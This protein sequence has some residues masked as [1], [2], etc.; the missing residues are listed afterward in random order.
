MRGW[1]IKPERAVEKAL[2]FAGVFAGFTLL[3]GLLFWPWMAHLST[4]LIGPPEDNMQDFWNT[5]YAVV[6]SDPRH[7]FYTTLIRFPEGTSLIYHS[8][9]YPQLFVLVPLSKLLGMDRATL[10]LLQNATMLLS[11]PLAG[12]GAFYLVR[13][14]VKAS[15]AALVGGFVFAFNPSHVAHAMHHIGVASIGFIPFCVLAYLRAVEER[16]IG[17]LCAAIVFYALSALSSWYNIF[18]L[19]YFIV[20]HTV[21]L[22]VRDH[23]PPTGWRLIA[24]LSCMTGTA[25]LLSPLLLP[26][27]LQYGGANAYF[28]GTNVYVADLAAYF[29]FPVT[30]L[31]AER[32]YATVSLFQAGPLEG[33][34]YLGLVNVAL[35][36]WLGWRA[37]GKKDPLLTYVLCGMAIFCVLASGAMLHAFGDTYAF[38]PLP[39]L[40]LSKL[41]F[42]AQVRTPSRAIVMVYLFLSIGVGYALALAW[43]EYRTAVGRGTVCVAAFLL[44]LDF[45]PTHL[46]MTDAACP[47]GLDIIARDSERG[48]G[49]LTRPGG[50]IEDE[51]AMLQQTCHGRPI[52]NGLV[53]RRLSRSLLDEL[54][55]DDFRAQREQLIRAHVK[56]IVLSA[57]TNGLFIWK[58][59]DGPKSLYESTY[60]PVYRDAKLTILRVY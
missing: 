7:F 19:A 46:A 10:I 26:M 40:V 45:T 53:S 16:S 60:R 49:V 18:Y 5:W 37:R 44:L 21:Y 4:A 20:F 52:V 15:A 12:T 27:A 47:K 36:L 31:L 39:D 56:Y 24:P 50:S 43:K 42:F 38:I 9:F 55:S 6:A 13:H 25:L 33:A 51:V 14:F 22:S 34:V 41:P 32:A 8:F 54:R 3:T 11:F 57:E 17:W 48:F 23:K 1:T 30:H 59:E 58:P 28:D 35:L 29:T 2:C